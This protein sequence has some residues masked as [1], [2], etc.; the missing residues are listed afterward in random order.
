MF[1]GW[2]WSHQQ[3]SHRFNLLIFLM[4]KW[5]D[6]LRADQGTSHNTKLKDRNCQ[7]LKLLVFCLP[8]EKSTILLYR[9]VLEIR[10]L[11]LVL[12]RFSKVS[13]GLALSGG[14]RGESVSLSFFSF[15]R[16]PAFL[17]SWSLSHIT[18]PS[19][20]HCY[21]SHYGVWPSCQQKQVLWDYIELTQIIQK[22]LPISKSLITFLPYRVTFTGSRD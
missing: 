1:S 18:S 22:S 3:L 8:Q 4:A 13:T 6:L 20:F 17:A 7:M 15:S 5:N 12:L 14:F 11:K 10:S 16:L 9:I 19:C 2:L 21:N